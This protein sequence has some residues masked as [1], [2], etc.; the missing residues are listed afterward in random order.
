M[1]R[2]RS[3]ES[4]PVSVSLVVQSSAHHVTAAQAARLDSNNRPRVAPSDRPRRYFMDYVLVPNRTSSTSQLSTNAP[5]S[6]S[7]G[8]ASNEDLS[9][10]EGAALEFRDELDGVQ[11]LGTRPPPDIHSYVA[12]R[13]AALSASRLAMSV[14][15][16]SIP[17]LDVENHRCLGGAGDGLEGHSAGGV[18]PVQTCQWLEVLSLAVDRDLNALFCRVHGIFLSSESCVRHIMIKHND[19]IP[20]CAEKT[21]FIKSVVSHV[22]EAI[23]NEIC[24]NADDIHP[25]KVL[26]KPL[27]I[28]STDSNI[29]YR[30][31]CPS[32]ACESWIPRNEARDKGKTKDLQHHFHRS[33]PGQLM[34]DLADVQGSWCQAVQVSGMHG[35]RTCIIE[36]ASY[37]PPS[38]NPV[39]NLAT[40]CIEGPPNANWFHKLD[41]NI[42]Y[43]DLG[44]GAAV[45]LQSL[46]HPPF[47]KYQLEAIQ[48]K[49]LRWLESGILHIRTLI[50]ERIKDAQTWA[51]SLHGTFLKTL[52]PRSVIAAYTSKIHH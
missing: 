52:K 31:K 9:E 38:P 26:H 22:S 33:H 30:Y 3:S 19:A 7:L 37:T 23:G 24:K 29:R 36:L 11:G 48:N 15:S 35:G 18:V 28:Q 2:R 16:T 6:V 34:P 12:K 39:I 27:D 43:Q 5:T 1:K 41:W 14:N 8:D 49:E 40:S 21:K 50:T 17:K 10:A 32:P 13:Q 4:V 20:P 45:F 46:I 47:T 42:F 25:P 51:S 44:A